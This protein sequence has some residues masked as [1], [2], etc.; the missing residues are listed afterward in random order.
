LPGPVAGAT[1]RIIGRNLAAE[2]TF[3]CTPMAPTDMVGTSVTVNG[4]PIQL[5][6]VSPTQIYAQIPFTVSGNITV[7]VTTPNGFVEQSI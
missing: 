6:Y 2:E 4:Q 5:L 7:R 3:L 1:I